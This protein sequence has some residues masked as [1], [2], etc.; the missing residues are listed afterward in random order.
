MNR[1]DPGEIAL[2]NF[3]QAQ[4]R[5]VRVRAEWVE[6][7][8]PVIARGGATG[9][10]PVCHPLLKE[11]RELERHVAELHGR[12]FPGHAGRPAEAVLQPGYL[13]PGGRYPNEESYGE[14]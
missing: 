7:G 1:A 12:L 9:Q 2:D 14:R 4:D 11:L 10:A 6:A 3:L 5:L 8:E 13:P